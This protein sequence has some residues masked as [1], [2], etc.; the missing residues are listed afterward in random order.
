MNIKTLQGVL[1]MSPKE[2]VDYFRDLINNDR[3]NRLR[4]NRKYFDGEHWAFNSDGRSN[5]TTSGKQVWGKS[6]KGNQDTDVY[7]RNASTS[8]DTSFS[9]GQL[10]IY[11]FIKKFIH[12]YQDYILGDKTGKCEVKYVPSDTLELGSAKESEALINEKISNL[13]KNIDSFIKEQVAKA[14]LNTVAVSKLVIDINDHNN[15]EVVCVDAINY[16]PIYDGSKRVGSCE[17]YMISPTEAKGYGVSSDK[18]AVYAKFIYSVGDTFY[19][20]ESVNGYILNLQEDG[21]AEILIEE[22][23]YDPYDLVSNLDHPFTVFDDNSLE[24]S[25]I[26]DWIDKNDNYNSSRTIEFLTNMYLAAP[27]ASIDFEIMKNLNIQI[28]DPAI[29]DALRSFQYSPFSIDTLP[30]KVTTGSTIP[31]S[32]YIGLQNTKDALFEDANIPAF[33]LSGSM[34]SGIAVETIELGMKMLQRKI[35]QKRDQIEKIVKD[36]TIKYLEV[37]GIVGVDRDDIVLDLPAVVG[38]SSKELLL[39]MKEY[40]IAGILPSK[41]VREEALELMNRAGDLD[42]VK[43]IENADQVELRSA[44]EDRR[45]IIQQESDVQRNLEERDRKRQELANL[46]SQISEIK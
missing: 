26:F 33:L 22:N 31:E 19:F 5:T 45:R 46:N 41:Y 44:I 3:N 16:Y 1:Q 13:W 7:Q 35:Q 20:I 40:S 18:E 24:D 32:F 11:N 4:I 23:A 42:R 17:M 2:R 6:R 43:D 37:Q 21:T 27:K 29:Q 30:I 25:E 12:L 14:V 38:L 34:P 10:S 8:S 39:Q 36:A 15:D 28:T 9:R